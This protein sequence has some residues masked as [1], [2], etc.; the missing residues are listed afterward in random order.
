VKQEIGGVSGDRP[1][2]A[3]SQENIQVYEV[4][5]NQPNH[6]SYRYPNN[7]I[8]TTKYTIFTFLPVN[9]FNQVCSCDFD[10]DILSV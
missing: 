9:L 3:G 2:T 6:S 8:R 4:V 1:T 5:V 10:M 7:Y